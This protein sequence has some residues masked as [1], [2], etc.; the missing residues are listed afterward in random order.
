MREI[1][2]RNMVYREQCKDWV[3]YFHTLEALVENSDMDV[4]ENVWEQYTGLKDKNGN[5]IYEGDIVEIEVSGLWA[6]ESNFIYRGKQKRKF[7]C[8]WDENRYAF[9]WH[10]ID[11]KTRPDKVYD[12]YDARLSEAKII[13][14]IHENQELLK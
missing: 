3:T 12:L 4:F 10:V 8:Y 5:E 14:N 1:K 6:D 2:F 11:S 7:K 9:M 13:G